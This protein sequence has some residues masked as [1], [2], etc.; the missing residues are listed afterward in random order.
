VVGDED[1]VGAVSEGGKENR[2]P[3]S[4]LPGGEPPEEQEENRLLATSKFFGGGGGGDGSSGKVPPARPSGL[5]RRFR[6][7]ITTARRAA[8]AGA[9]GES[10]LHRDR[11]SGRGSGG[12]GGG[13]VGGGGGG[14]EASESDDTGDHSNPWGADYAYPRLDVSSDRAVRD[15]EAAATG[16]GRSGSGIAA[17]GRRLKRRRTLGLGSLAPGGMLRGLEGVAGSGTAAGPARRSK[18]LGGERRVA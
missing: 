9:P 15:G 4:S 10:S 13:G 3:L 14:G 12:G 2:D 7:P 5:R 1:N 8:A 17:G 11:G 18:S 16:G 6:P